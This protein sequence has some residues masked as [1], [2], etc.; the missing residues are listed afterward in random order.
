MLMDS[1]PHAMMHWAMPAMMRPA[2]IAMVCEPEE[3]KRLTVT[4]GT[5]WGK[6]ARNAAMRAT[7]APDSPSGVAQPMITSSIVSGGSLG[8]RRSK[9]SMTAAETIDDVI[10]G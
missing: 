10:M 5:A 4:A 7:F 6:P 1:V 8:T 9:S 3:Q 2:A